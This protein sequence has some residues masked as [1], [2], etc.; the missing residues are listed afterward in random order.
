[1]SDPSQNPAPADDALD[2]AD[3]ILLRFL[4]MLLFYV[5]LAL[6]R[7]VVLIVAVFQAIHTL[8]TGAPQTDLRRFGAALS[9]F[10]QQVVAYLTWSSDHKPFPFADWPND[11]QEA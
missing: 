5:I 8:I 3:P 11:D 7:F 2:E 1:M 9:R 10:L 4:Y 6:S